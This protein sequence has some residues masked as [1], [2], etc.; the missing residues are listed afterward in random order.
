VREK[1]DGHKI[2]SPHAWISPT[3]VLNVLALP[4]L[5]VLPI[6]LPKIFTNKID[7]SNI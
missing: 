1:E 2:R 7:I 4:P 5:V 3:L 6:P